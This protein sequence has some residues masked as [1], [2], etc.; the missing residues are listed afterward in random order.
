MKIKITVL[1][2]LI[3]LIG[4]GCGAKEDDKPQQEIQEKHTWVAATC[5]SPS[6]CSDCGET[7]GEPLGHDWIPATCTEP[8]KCSRCLITDGEALGHK[9]EEANCALPKTCTR[10]GETEGKALGHSWL[11]ATCAEPK[12]CST[13]GETEGKPLGHT[14]DFTVIVKETCSTAGMEEG[15]CSVCGETVTKEIPATNDHN[16]GDWKV[17]EKASCTAE[18]KEVRKCKT[19]EYTE[20]H[21]LEKLDH[22][23]DEKW[24]IVTEA[25]SQKAGK[26]ATHCKVCGAEI[27]TQ[28]YEL[29]SANGIPIL[30]DTSDFTVTGS[31]TYK[32]YG[33]QYLIYVVEAKKTIEAEVKLVIKD[34]NGDILDTCED[35]ISLTKGKKN[36]FKLITDSDYINSNSE[37]KMTSSTSSPFWTGAEDAVEVVK[38]NKSGNRFYITVKQTKEDLGG[39][40]EL[41]ML[42]FSGD[43]LLK[44]D[45]CYYSV[46]ADDLEHKGDEAIMD[47]S[48]YGVDY[49]SVDFFY[50]DR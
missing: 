32:S 42:F 46:Y 10:C 11:D 45:E 29:T 25:T 5:T 48:I 21:I 28:K 18:G 6:I 30:K 31:Y 19:C 17:E 20:T 12:T 34:K 4:A 22:K 50:E 40:A 2:M 13:C 44:A 14:V 15:T 43:K 16:F 24:V 47:I 41:K 38:Y 33:Y 35:D 3:I 49:K 36:Y 27:Q 9:W 1:I 7:K 26:K 8:K 23:D 39:F 37:Y